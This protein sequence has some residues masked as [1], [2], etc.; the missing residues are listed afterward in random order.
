MNCAVTIS[1]PADIQSSSDCSK[2]RIYFHLPYPGSASSSDSNIMP[3]KSNYPNKGVLSNLPLPGLVSSSDCY[4]SEY[5]TITSTFK[6]PF[7]LPIP[8]STTTNSPNDS[9]ISHSTSISVTKTDIGNI[10]KLLTEV[11]CGLD[12]SPHIPITL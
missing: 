11:Q 10:N 12:K 1:Q 6:V 7:H 9:Q 8:G 2:N 5:T 4:C 3:Q